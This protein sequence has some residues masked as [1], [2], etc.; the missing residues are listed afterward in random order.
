MQA[1]TLFLL[2]SQNSCSNNSGT[3]EISEGEIEYNVKYLK[4]KKSSFIIA[5]LP[6]QVTTYFKE[7]SSCTLIEEDLGLFKL[8]YVL[9]GDEQKSYSLLQIFDKKYA[10]ESNYGELTYGYDEMRGLKIQHTD[11]SKKIAG[12]TCMHALAIFNSEKDTINLYYTDKIKLLHPNLNNPFKEIDGVLLEF[13]VNLAGINMLFT[14]TEIR[15]ASVDPK[16]FSLPENYL[17]VTEK[18][19]Q[20]EINKYL[21]PSDK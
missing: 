16:R 18:Q 2:L 4:D 1:I 3:G 11:K 6:S 10:Y 17:N 20:E 13:S 12:Y 19:M 8:A 7:N 9:N 21:H 14:A 15:S 5:L